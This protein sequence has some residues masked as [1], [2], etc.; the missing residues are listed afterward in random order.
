MENTL[1]FKFDNALKTSQGY[2]ALSKIRVFQM[3]ADS[4]LDIL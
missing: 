2:K 3:L 4:E 1:E